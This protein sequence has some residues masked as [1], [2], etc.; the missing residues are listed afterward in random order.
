MTDEL[1]AVHRAFRSE[2]GR[3]V[4]ILMRTLGDLEAAE[5]AVQDAFTAAAET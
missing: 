3:T 4:A 2:Y 5:D 1:A